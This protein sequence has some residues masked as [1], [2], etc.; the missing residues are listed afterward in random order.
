MAENNLDPA[1]IALVEKTAEE[2]ACKA[3]QKTLTMLGI[4]PKNPVEFQKDTAHLRV[5]RKR[6]ESLEE[7][8][9]LIILGA[10]VSGTLAVVWI[11]FKH[12][13]GFG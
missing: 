12:K 7:K 6:M 13:L 4:D 8:G 1:T 5:W 3:I 11:G 10:V 2:A 9:L